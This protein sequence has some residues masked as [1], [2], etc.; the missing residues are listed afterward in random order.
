VTVGAALLIYALA[1]GTLG[2]V[3][4]RADGWLTRAPRLGATMLLAASWSTVTALFLAGLTIAL[5]GTALSSGLSN[6]LG[7]CIMRLRA[8]YATPGGAAVAGAGLTLSATIAMR[9]TWALLR[10]WRIRGRERLRHRTLIALCGRRASAADPVLLDQPHAAVY[11]LAGRR[12]TVVVTRGAV[13]LLTEPEL[14]AVLAHEHA[15]GRSRH[16]RALAA[17]SVVGA[18][19]PELPLVRSVGSGVRALIEMHADDTAVRRHDPETLATALVTLATSARPVSPAVLAAAD[20]E[21]V[22]RVRRLLV[23]PRPLA[24]R[25]RCSV[26]VGTAGLALVPLLLALAPAVVA[27]NQPPVHQP[28]AHAAATRP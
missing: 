10:G 5:P 25:A 24:P 23:P 19:L 7:A 11:C 21:A 15:H 1:L 18:V 12:R 22:A 3:L 16:H 17:A 2:P 13:E 6:L 20:T 8:A 28:V 4:L 26:R 27:A 9:T 14:A